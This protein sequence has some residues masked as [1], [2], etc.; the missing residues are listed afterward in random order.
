MHRMSATHTPAAAASKKWTLHKLKDQRALGG[1]D[2]YPSMSAWQQTIPTSPWHSPTHQSS[3]GGGTTY[4]LP[5]YAGWGGGVRIDPP[6]SPL[7][8]P[9]TTPHQPE[10]AELVGA[11]SGGDGGVQVGAGS[12]A[13]AVAQC[14]QYAPKRTS[15]PTTLLQ[16]VLSLHSTSAVNPDTSSVTAP[17]RINRQTTAAVSG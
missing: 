8:N 9:S 11:G 15:A 6:P 16:R 1:N 3:W 13:V 2:S 14:A 12:A 7:S 10:A 4:S 17:T 5:P